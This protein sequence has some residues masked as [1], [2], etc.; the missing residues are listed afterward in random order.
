ML[1]HTEGILEGHIHILGGHI[2]GHPKQNC[3]CALSYSERFSRW[4]YFT[5]QSQNGAKMQ[6]RI[7]SNIGIYC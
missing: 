7:V 3:M 1:Y 2:I 4:S 6:L 5:V